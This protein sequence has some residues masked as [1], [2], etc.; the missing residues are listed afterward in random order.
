MSVVTSALDEHYCAYAVNLV[1]LQCTTACV[2]CSAESSCAT[3]ATTAINSSDVLPVLLSR[4]QLCSL[5]RTACGA[6]TSIIDAM[7]AAITDIMIKLCYGCLVCM[8]VAS[9]SRIST[10]HQYRAQL[11]RWL[12]HA[13]QLQLPCL[14]AQSC[15]LSC[16]HCLTESCKHILTVM[17]KILC[18]HL[19]HFR[20][21]I[22]IRGLLPGPHG[23]C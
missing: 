12:L 2:F 15:K 9:A 3:A 7:T 19:L 23:R 13:C 1:L 22:I 21:C 5:H 14:G 8:T 4:C 10:G 11:F 6:A 20:V 18:R 16:K 17:T